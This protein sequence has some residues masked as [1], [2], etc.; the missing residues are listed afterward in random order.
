[1][2]VT[3]KTAVVMSERT[4]LRIS[5]SDARKFLQ[6]LVSND[7]KK[8]DHGVVYTALLTPQGKYLVDFFL[9]PDGN[10][11]LVDV[12]TI[13][14][15]DLTKRLTMYK[16]RADV[17]IAA[18]DITVSCGLGPVP[19][20]AFVDPRHA[21]MGW[22]YYGAPIET[23]QQI[24]WDAQRV[25]LGIPEFG[26]ELTSESYIL[27]MGFARLN[28]VDFRKGCYVGQE[29]TARMKHKT[30]LRKGLARVTFQGPVTCGQT[31]LSQGKAVGTVHTVSGQ[32]ALCYVRFDRIEGLGTETAQAHQIDPLI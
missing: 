19:A 10:D 22:R 4:I 25:A 31:L 15:G 12:D 8:L 14:A 18:T 26:A 30:E 17:A 3:Q 13:Q 9:V 24:D 5:G 16:L 29:V 32:Q 23:T 11:I 21:D 20:G 28:G 6:N 7:V 27:E 1:M 2:L